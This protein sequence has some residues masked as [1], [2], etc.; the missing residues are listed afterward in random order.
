VPHL[1]VK[2]EIGNQGLI[3]TTDRF[4]SALSDIVR[5]SV[6]GHMQLA[7]LPGTADLVDEYADA[8][9]MDYVA[10]E[11]GQRQTARL[12]L[13]AIERYI[14]TGAL[15]D[16]GCWVGFLLDE[17]RARGWRT[18]GLEP[19]RFA[20]EYARDQLQLDV[21]T[22]DLFEAE[23][24]ARGFEATVLADVLEHFPDPGAALERIR[25]WVVPGGLVFLALPDA[26]SR[27]ARTLGP[28]WWSVIPTHVQYFTRASLTTLL[29]RRSWEPLWAGTAPKSFSVGYYLERLGGYSP[30]LARGAVALARGAGVAERL[31][32]P[33]FRDRMALVARAPRS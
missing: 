31:W 4:G 11:I 15:L 22:T 17:A 30:G 18:V 2:H 21:H 19:S 8:A 3:P 33:D 29:R 14:G 10:E 16:V 9:S 24:P 5:C 26:G 7:R 20:S 13:D 1:T 25:S 27:V 6:C 28:R 23:L 12:T 32:A